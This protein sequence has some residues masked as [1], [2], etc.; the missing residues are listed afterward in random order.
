MR[1]TVVSLI[2][3]GDLLGR[4]CVGSIEEKFSTSVVD[5]RRLVTC[6]AWVGKPDLFPVLV[7]EGFEVCHRSLTWVEIGKI[8]NTS[9]NGLFKSLLIFETDSLF[10]HGKTDAS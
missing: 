7:C 1:V 6:P 8:K 10:I 9:S 3:G 2:V 4:S 5:D